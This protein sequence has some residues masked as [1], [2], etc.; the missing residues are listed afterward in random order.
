M[1]KYINDDKELTIVSVR[2]TYQMMLYL[3]VEMASEPIVEETSVYIVG[4]RR[5]RVNI[6]DK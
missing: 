1:E 2:S 4:R 5:G 3:I 6:A